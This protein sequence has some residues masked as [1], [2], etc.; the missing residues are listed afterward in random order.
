MTLVMALRVTNTTCSPAECRPVRISATHHLF[1]Q[2]VYRGPLRKVLNLSY[3]FTWFRHSHCSCGLGGSKPAWG[4]QEQNFITG[5]RL[6][7]T[8]MAT[9][10][11]IIITAVTTAII[12]VSV[13]AKQPAEP[14]KQ[15]TKEHNKWF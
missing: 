14:F 4:S 5:R 12:A 2:R 1:R 13:A 10:V 8:A 3:A 9:I 7:T 15:T 11:I 6:A